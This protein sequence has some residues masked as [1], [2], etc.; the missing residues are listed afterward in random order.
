ML[1]KACVLLP[2]R[3]PI[4]IPE[5]IE[6][7]QLPQSLSYLRHTNCLSVIPEASKCRSTALEYVCNM[8]GLCMEYVWNIHVNARCLEYICFHNFTC[9]FHAYSIHIPDPVHNHSVQMPCIYCTYCI[10]FPERDHTHS[11]HI[12]YIIH[13]CSI[14][15]L[16]VFHA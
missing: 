9:V 16:C 4:E 6:G 10:R 7:H 13:A 5:I 12:P 2:L 8:H 3:D 11:V 15:M 1:Q 14:H